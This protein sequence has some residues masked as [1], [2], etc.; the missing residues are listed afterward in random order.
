MWLQGKLLGCSK[1][2]LNCIKDLLGP[3]NPPSYLRYYA[4]T[5][6]FLKIVLIMTTP[7]ILLSIEV[8]GPGVCPY[9]PAMQ[10]ESSLSVLQSPPEFPKHLKSTLVVNHP[11][12]RIDNN[13]RRMQESYVWWEASAILI[14]YELCIVQKAYCATPEKKQPNKKMPMRCFF[15][16]IK[17]KTA[18]IMCR[19]YSSFPIRSMMTNC[20]TWLKPSVFSLWRTKNW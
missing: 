12:W 19:K 16:K 20:C 8:L 3:I 5:A 11:G 2:F 7:L 9:I 1:Q 18:Q 10:A 4:N 13:E 6:L 17:L 15:C 14:G